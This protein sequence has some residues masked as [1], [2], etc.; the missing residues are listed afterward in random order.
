MS[1][2]TKRNIL[3][4]IPFG[5]IWLIAGWY[6]IAIEAM[7]TGN[8]NQDPDILLS[9][10]LP[11]FIFASAASSFI[12]LCIGLIEVVWLERVFINKSFGK[13]LLFKFVL[14]VLVLFIAILILYP[15]ASAIEQNKSV[16]DPDNW[17]RLIR[18]I[19]SIGFI[20]TI[21]GIAFSLLL[22][23]IYAGI[24]EN[25]GHR[26]FINMLT[27]KYQEPK[28]EERI[29]LFLDMMSS[30]TIAEK[31]GHQL[32]FRFLQDYY[33]SLSNSIID[34][35]GEVYQYIGDEVVI[36][37]NMKDGLSASN[38]IHCFFSMRKDLEAKKD[39]FINK[40]GVFPAF[41]GGL[42]AGKVT[43]GEIGA[44]KKEIFYTGDVLNTTARIQDLCSKYMTDLL[45]SAKLLSHLSSIENY[46]FK[47]VGKL[48]LRGKQE[49][50]E[51]YQ[52]I[53][54]GND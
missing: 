48:D 32:N 51:V 40:Y 11:V 22:S 37:W 38:C 43:T 41:K 50:I 4:V 53:K 26:M 27:G 47:S 18:F 46:H 49:E 15:I 6:N 12:G 25:I 29:F 28:E 17:H 1:P 7:A 21:T 8:V 3:R 5:V 30:T 44:L 42:H 52:L 45:I 39:K 19:G 2:K 31:L 36:T 33:A 35:K 20:S 23:L 16:I 13:K 9:M 14:Y 10:T 54:E 24:S 34:H